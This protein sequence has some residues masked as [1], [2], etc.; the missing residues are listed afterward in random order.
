[1][2]GIIEKA[3][4]RRA[5]ISEQRLLA[6]LQELLVEVRGGGEAV[7][8][9]SRLDRDL[10]LDSLAR[11][12]LMLRLQREFGA[13]LPE[14]VLVE[15]ETPRDLLAAIAEASAV[16][17]N[18]EASPRL[19][20]SSTQLH[21]I[22][23]SAA[24]LMDVLEW[25]AQG[26]PGRIYVHLYSGDD[27]LAS[28]TYRE[29]YD[30]AR[31]VAAGLRA[32]GVAPGQAVALMLPTGREFLGA[33]F[34]ILLA[35]AVVAPLYPPVRLSALEEHLRRQ[36]A[37]LNNCEAPLFIAPPEVRALSP[38]IKGLAPGL[39]A[40]TTVEELMSD[41]AP[42]E[43][44][45]RTADD[46]ALLQYTSGSTGD[47]KG[48]LLTHA[49][50]LANIRAM[51]QAVAVR[52][53]EDVFVSWLPLY[54]DMGLIGAC[55]GSLY[56]GMPLVLMSPLAFLARP[57]RWL[58]AIHRHRGSLS[59]GPNFAYELC[60]TKVDDKELAG[61]DLSS[62]RVAFN[63]AEQVSADT[64]RRFAS[65]YA[66]C[67]FRAE[68]LA[69]VYGLAESSVG[70][71]FPPL[72]RGPV[73]DCIDR[74]KLMREGIA[75]PS[76]DSGATI[77]IVGC[78]R[79]LPG[80]AIRV[81]DARD[82]IC[83][84]R[85]EGRV[86]FRGPSS[87][88]GYFKNPQATARLMQGEWLDSGDRGY[89]VD[90]EIF[91]TGRVKDIIIRAGHN[92]Y[93]YELEEAVGDL[94]GIRRGGVA[95]FASRDLER[96]TE[97]LVIVAETRERRPAS[98]EQL[99]AAVNEAVAAVIGNPPDEVV[100]AAPRAVLKTSS[101]K[102]RRD[103]TRLRYEQGALEAGTAPLWRQGV[104]L[105]AAGAG[106]WLRRGMAGTVAWSYAAY[107]WTVFI[108]GAAAAI[109]GVGV[110]PSLRARQRWCK[111]VA[112]ATAA[113]AGLR[114]ATEDPQHLR[115]D[116][117]QVVVANHASY[118]DALV[119][120]AALPTGLHYVTKNELAT[121]PLVGWCLKRY[122][123]EFVERFDLRRS[124][125]AARIL[126]ERVRGGASLM[127]F[128]EGTFGPAP[129]L[130]PFRMGAFVAAAKAGAPVVPVGL[131]GT[132]AVLPPGTW[133]PRRGPVTITIAAPRRAKGEDWRAAL[134]LRDDVRQEIARLSA[135]PALQ[136]L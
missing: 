112:R 62:W 67:G 14:R 15:A 6:V 52:P 32:R 103:A 81:V 42:S 136:P 118:L 22:P 28:L 53:D 82:R 65:R 68:A 17:G 64:L 37:I 56:Y 23:D 80:H 107:A 50:L 29:L 133:R 87:C 129:G 71:A 41:A 54:H 111:S 46:I 51:G 34:G 57:S 63:G 8:M 102:V 26:A 121:Q 44:P 123:C 27:P 74:E 73:I 31:H 117:A 90:G 45:A 105:A 72:S 69:P 61:L 115:G 47:P 92:I 104:R 132:R 122:G 10:G 18:V 43:R 30:D 119:L 76:A 55:L 130:R 48:V 3:P 20:R 134:E 124:A 58:R 108:M 2:N 113:A 94:A 114:L 11:V 135:E 49:N 78:G 98:R 97:R 40:V 109:V 70:L 60:A 66:A 33:F 110:L 96:G 19:S 106:T 120:V 83:E 24:T 85:L 126:E 95:A 127:F 9:N 93:P 35:G 101:G 39:R 99:R 4:I 12:E 88:Q 59:A 128:P 36:A 77:N 116:R 16:I 84:D 75:V 100:L 13:S 7:H 91:I 21:G 1:M 89:L 125:A 38:L 86:Q 79:A 25:H 5:D 131:R